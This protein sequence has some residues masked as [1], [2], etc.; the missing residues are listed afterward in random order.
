MQT[1]NAVT[2]TALMLAIVLSV[3]GATT[4]LRGVIRGELE[5][6][7]YTTN[8]R[9]EHEVAQIREELRTGR[10]NTEREM[11]AIRRVVLDHQARPTGTRTGATA[12]E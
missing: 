11:N 4:H 10:E 12:R 9:I 2:A 8:I 1:G 3:G 7:N 6:S 5:K